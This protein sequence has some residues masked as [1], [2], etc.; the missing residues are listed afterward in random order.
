MVWNTFFHVCP[1]DREGGGDLSDLGNAHIEPTHFK[2]GLP[3]T[4]N[5]ILVFLKN[6]TMEETFVEM[7]FKICHLDVEL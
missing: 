4:T 3:L 1:F 2:K 6:K 7:H 5:D